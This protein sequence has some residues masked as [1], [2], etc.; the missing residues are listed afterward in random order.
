M[1]VTI[2]VKGVK[3]LT[4]K[5]G[6]LEKLVKVQKAIKDEAEE[7]KYLLQQY[8][9]NAHGP[10]PLLHVKDKNNEKANKVRRAFFAKLK[11]GEISVPY[12]RKMGLYK[13]WSVAVSGAGW[14][15]TVGNNISYNDWV[16]GPG[17]TTGHANSGWLTVDKAKE[18]N[19]AGIIER[20]TAAL[21]EEVADVG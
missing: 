13:D 6:K 10:N 2:T 14:V 19:E 21:E 17:Q 1:A 8:P 11:S 4:E 16:Q 7:L 20:I 5:L 15:A 3:E 9:G 18:Q 12:G